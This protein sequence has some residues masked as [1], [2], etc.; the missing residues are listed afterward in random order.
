MKPNATLL[1]L[2]TILI[3]LPPAVKPA[4]QPAAHQLTLADIERWM[5]ELSNWGRWGKEDQIGTVNLI[6][7]TK[8]KQ[9]A[10]LVKEGVSVSLSHDAEKNTAPDNP[11]PFIDQ[12]LSTSATPKAFSHGDLFTIAH[13]GLAHTHLD[14]LCHFFY[15]DH[16]YNVFSRQEVTAQGAGRLSVIQ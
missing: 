16:M 15:K 14:S 1:I 10:R 4:D 13:H 11:R 8:R 5:T 3:A 9:A 7:P 6:T 12:M 2:A